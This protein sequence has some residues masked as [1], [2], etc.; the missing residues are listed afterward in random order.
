[1][2]I[3][4]YVYICVYIYGIYDAIYYNM[5]LYHIYYNMIL[6]HKY[7]ERRHRLP[8]MAA[9]MLAQND[10]STTLGAS[11]IGVCSP[12]VY[13]A[14]LIHKHTANISDQHPSTVQPYKQSLQAVPNLGISLLGPKQSKL[15]PGGVFRSS[16]QKASHL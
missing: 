15:R 14:C 4:I 7:Y 13:E 1:M 3:C 10:A 6:Y 12:G 16:T 5:I 11:C 8:S 2:Y 9:L